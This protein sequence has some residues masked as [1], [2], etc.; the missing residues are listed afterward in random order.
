MALRPGADVRGIRPERRGLRAY[1]KVPPDDGNYLEARY[2][3]VALATERF[4]R[5]EGKAPAAEQKAAATDL[6]AVC[7]SS[8]I[9]WIIPPPRHRPRLCGPRRPIATTCG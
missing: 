5:L 3:L 7:T 9:C 6:F 8:R 4:S 1:D 2:R